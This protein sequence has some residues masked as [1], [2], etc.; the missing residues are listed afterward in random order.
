M[1]IELKVGMKY[2]GLTAAQ[3][4]QGEICAAPAAYVNQL[5]KKGKVLRSG[6]ALMTD[7]L[8]CIEDS[9][10]LPD[11][12]R[13]SELINLSRQRPAPAVI[14]YENS[15][16]LI[17]DK[18]AG[19]AVHSSVGHETSNLTALLQQQIDKGDKKYRISPVQRLDLET[20]G[21]CLFG[22]GRKALGELGKVLMA[23]ELKKTYLALVAGCYR[24]PEELVSE[25]HAKGKLKEAG[26]LV[27]T[28]T[29]N[30]TASLL[31]I[32]LQSGRQHQ[33][34]QQM[35]Q[36]GCPLYG[37][38][39]YHGPCPA[40]L[41]RVFLHSHQLS[42]HSPF[43]GDPIRVTAPLPAELVDFLARI[44]LRF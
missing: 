39:R 16:L 29:S 5:F 14:L 43:G 30:P 11:S 31:Q 24:G 19:L 38:R 34:R 42:F 7:T 3:F 26:C 4:L 13:L 17:A 15:M 6:K 23:H 32:E 12:A 22:K 27:K 35:A 1:A 44:G 8:L 37:D 40:E 33:I 9:I 20:S 2:A 25:V 10:C 41:P 18:P 36:Q 28:L 21:A